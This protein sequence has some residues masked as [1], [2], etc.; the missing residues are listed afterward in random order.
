[1]P[2]VEDLKRIGA[3]ELRHEENLSIEEVANSDLVLANLLEQ[4]RTEE[5]ALSQA[6]RG[7]NPQ[8]VADI[9]SA[10]DSIQKQKESKFEAILNGRSSGI[11]WKTKFEQD[12]SIN[13]PILFYTDG[14][15]EARNKAGEFFPLERCEALC[16]PAGLNGSAEPARLVNQLSD[17]VVR[18]IGHEPDDDV[19]LL[20][21]C[22]EAGLAP[23][24]PSAAA[25]L[26]PVRPAA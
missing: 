3:Q 25:G 8:R 22:R 16:P 23:A 7:T 15:S 14:A 20:M 10:L 5:V 13:G 19:A 6:R 1:M 2:S 26:L 12:V 11:G 24:R 21:V 4:Q 9:Q 17:E 18:H